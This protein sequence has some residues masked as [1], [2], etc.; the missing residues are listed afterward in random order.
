MSSLLWEIDASQ[1][2]SQPHLPSYYAS[3]G[4]FI[5]EPGRMD[6]FRNANFPQLCLFYYFVYAMFLLLNKIWNKN[7]FT[8][9]VPTHP[10]PLSIV[11][12]I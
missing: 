10:P 2:S 6:N 3:F 4:R 5:M 1:A 8:R 11:S 9:K 12:V 7:L